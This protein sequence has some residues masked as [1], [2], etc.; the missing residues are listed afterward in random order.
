M[1][2]KKKSLFPDLEWLI[3]RRLCV[4]CPYER[5]CHINCTTCNEFEEL[6]IEIEEELWLDDKR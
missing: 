3:Y 5:A 6:L 2:D 1:E 4:G